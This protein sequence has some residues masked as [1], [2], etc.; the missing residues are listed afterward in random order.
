MLVFGFFAVLREKFAFLPF[1][2]VTQSLDNSDILV[3]QSKYV[4][5]LLCEKPKKLDSLIPEKFYFVL[6]L[7]N[8]SSFVSTFIERA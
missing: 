6:T 5:S 7:P 8:F 3:L 2:P 1:I 4:G